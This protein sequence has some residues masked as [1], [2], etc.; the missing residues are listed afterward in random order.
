M[1]RSTGTPRCRRDTSRERAGPA[2]FPVDVLDQVA[3]LRLALAAGDKALGR[4]A[5]QLASE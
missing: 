1:P 3:L 4:Q 2:M 5:V